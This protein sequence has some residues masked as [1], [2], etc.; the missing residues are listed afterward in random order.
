MQNIKVQQNNN[1]S[2]VFSSSMTFKEC[3]NILHY[4]RLMYK[5]VIGLKSTQVNEENQI[6]I[7]SSWVL[8]VMSEIKKK[9][10]Q[11]GIIYE[12]ENSMLRE[13]KL[14]QVTNEYTKKYN[15]ELTD[16]SNSEMNLGFVLTQL[17]NFY[18]K[19]DN[20]IAADSQSSWTF[21]GHYI[22]MIID[23]TN[24][25]KECYEQRSYKIFS[26]FKELQTFLNKNRDSMDF[27]SYKLLRKKISFIRDKGL[28]Y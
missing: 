23:C 18:F 4:C 9:I 16:L 5:Y 14:R 1:L 21:L 17:Q 15:I 24:M 11:N 27:Q 10:S 2:K 13:K 19:I 7:L 26:S 8:L 28:I 12:G 22:V 20:Q 6:R 25:L 3:V